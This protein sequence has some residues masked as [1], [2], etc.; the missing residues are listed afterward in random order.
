MKKLTL[1]MV[2]LASLLSLTACSHENPLTSQPTAETR[3]FVQ[4]ASR[5]VEQQWHLTVFP[6]GEMYYDCMMDNG[7][8]DPASRKDPNFCEKFYTAMV[9][10]AN[11]SSGAYQAMTV[12]DLSDNVA[13]RTVYHLPMNQE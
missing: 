2:T 3:A 11:Q 5:A 9:T 10:Y 8:G 6:P 1:T 13:F 7:M 12:K 4:E